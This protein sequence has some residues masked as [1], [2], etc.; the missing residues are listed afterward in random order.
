[1]TYEE[2]REANKLLTE[3]YISLYNTYC[4]ELKKKEEVNKLNRELK[5]INEEHRNLNGELREELNI[6]KAL[7]QNAKGE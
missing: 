4:E 1:M 7:Y 5:K 3:Q 2:L 6:Y